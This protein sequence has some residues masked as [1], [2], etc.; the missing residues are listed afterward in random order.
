ML[1]LQAQAQGFGRESAAL[2]RDRAALEG[3][4]HGLPAQTRSRLGE[5]DRELAAVA[6]EAAEQD[7]ARQIVVRAPQDGTVGA[8]L[9]DVGQSVSPASALATLVPA[10]ATLQ[11]HCMRR[12]GRSAS[13]ARSRRCGCASRPSCTRSSAT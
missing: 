5:I 12:P 3:E 1:G 9:A 2:A 10:G 13:C 7:T 11:A 4:L 6:R 8:V